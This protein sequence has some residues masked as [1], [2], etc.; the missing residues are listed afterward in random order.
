MWIKEFG[1]E[2][3]LGFSLLIKTDISIKWIDIKWK[4]RVEGDKFVQAT[5]KNDDSWT[6]I[7]LEQE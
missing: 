5:L 1:F 2:I 4:L 3:K 7:S 6:E